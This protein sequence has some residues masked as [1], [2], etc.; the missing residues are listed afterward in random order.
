MTDVP[1]LA[2][3]LVGCYCYVRGLQEPTGGRG[4]V[5][6]WEA[7][8]FTGWAFLIRQFALLA[9]LVFAGVLL[10]N[11]LWT[12]RWRWREL[13]LI[14]L[15][16]GLIMG[17]WTFYTRDWPP[18]PTSAAAMARAQVYV[19]KE[20]WLRVFLLRAFAILP[21]TAL[22]AWGAVVIPRARRWW[23]LAVA[24]LVAA[25]T[26]T[27]N[28][29]TE[30]WIMVTTP[31]FTARL[32]PFGLDLPQEPFTFGGAGNLL[33]VGGLDFFEYNQA[34]IWSPE[35]WRAL[36]VAGLALA[37]LLLAGM[38]AGLGEWLRAVWRQRA[39]R[40]GL[41]PLAGCYLL[42]AGIFVAS[43]AF[44]GDLFDR[45]ILGF[46]PFVI[47]FV[48]R[49]AAGWGRRAWAYSGGALALLALFTVLAKADQID[50]DNARWAAGRW[51]QA[52][53]IPAHVGFDWDNWVQV[54]V[55]EFQVADMLLPNYRIEQTF[56]YTSRLSGGTTRTVLAQS[57]ADVP[58][59]PSPAP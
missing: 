4:L 8:L 5:W 49:G 17:A 30:T 39:A 46:L 13:L 53:G 22:M 36:W 54:G 48:V 10:L 34:P 18:T 50:H 55:A 31:P 7:G 37:V 52:R 21:V 44:P 6:L 29:H 43:L 58:P 32:G 57:Q 28:L 23:L 51:M 24:V 16:P 19:F 40:P 41:T 11:G 42:G 1:F 12:R 14:V 3:L 20:P 38:A 45:Y 33:R 27:I 25:A 47:L 26:F 56:P 9:P 2:L 59:L 15:V 35:A